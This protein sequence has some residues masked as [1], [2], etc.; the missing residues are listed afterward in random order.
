MDTKINLASRAEV[1]MFDHN[2]HRQG[3]FLPGMNQNAG[4]LQFFQDMV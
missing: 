3:V 1:A 2:V 4:L